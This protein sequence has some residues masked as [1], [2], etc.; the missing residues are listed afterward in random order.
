MERELKIGITV[1]LV[2]LI[3]GL[4][5]FFN[6]GS[7]VTLSLLNPIVLVILS[8]VFYF[9][10]LKVRGSAYILTVAF[11][12]ILYALA[13]PFTLEYLSLKLK[14]HDVIRFIDTVPFALISF[15]LFFGILLLS[16][17]R[18][19]SEID[20]RGLV[21]LPFLLLLTVVA[22]FFAQHHL[23]QTILMM[24]FFMSYF[25]IAQRNTP[26]DKSAARICSIIYFV[27]VL[28]ESVEFLR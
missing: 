25:V 22:A 3:Y 7:F 18:L 11:A 5:T 6:S 15:I 26:D 2:F 8:M 23:L 27:F 28:L 20:K 17:Y 4:G 1:F 19:L 14:L 13:D 10:N 9:M 16:V 12:F 21:L 24:A